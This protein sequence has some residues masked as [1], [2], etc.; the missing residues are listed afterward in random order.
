MRRCAS[1]PRDDQQCLGRNDDAGSDLPDGWSLL[2][3]INSEVAVFQP[4][5]LTIA[6]DMQDNEWLTR[7]QAMV[8]R[9][10]AQWA[11]ASSYHPQ[12]RR[13]AR[14]FQRQHG[15][16]AGIIAQSYN[17]SA[18]Q[19]VV[20]TESHDETRLERQT[21][22]CRNRSAGHADSFASQKPIDAGRALV[23]TARAFR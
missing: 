21:P 1:T 6:E 7:P 19:R 5:K 20:Y 23:F 4:W 9:L 22:G 18:F 13:R 15:A 3:W 16:V 2:Q 8:A 12:C 10:S 11:R 14:R 17:A